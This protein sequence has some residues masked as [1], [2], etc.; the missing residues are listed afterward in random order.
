M[1]LVGEGGGGG[2]GERSRDGAVVRAFAP[3]QC[4]PGSIPRL[5]VIFV[6]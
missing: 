2:G 4:G 1:S 5:G 3:N 6:G